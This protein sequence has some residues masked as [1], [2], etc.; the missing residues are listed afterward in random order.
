MEAQQ[1]WDGMSIGQLGHHAGLH[2]TV[3][4]EGKMVGGIL[5]ET[6]LW[7]SGV[8]AG[9]AGDGTYVAIK[10]DTPIGGGERAG[11][12]RRESR[13]P[14]SMATSLSPAAIKAGDARG[15]AGQTHSPDPAVQAGPQESLWLAADRVR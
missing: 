3:N 2:V 5:S 1:P 6:E 15:P 13:G 7:V 11:L 4:L 12:F 9:S 10:L 14:R 8:V